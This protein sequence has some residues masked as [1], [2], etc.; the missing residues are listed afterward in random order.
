MSNAPANDELA[1]V[2]VPIQNTTT[3]PVLSTGAFCGVLGKCALVCSIIWLDLRHPYR[4]RF[5]ERRAIVEK[6]LESTESPVALDRDLRAQS[7]SLRC[8]AREIPPVFGS[9]F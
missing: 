1:S 9:F 7:T 6:V 5:L 4:H 8:V 2:W 3:S